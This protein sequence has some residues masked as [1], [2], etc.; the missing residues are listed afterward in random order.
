MAWQSNPA[1]IEN[2]KFE[3]E[4]DI[5]DLVLPSK[6]LKLSEFESDDIKQG[7]IN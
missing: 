7:L 2:I 3:E 4:V 5:D 6:P 1:M